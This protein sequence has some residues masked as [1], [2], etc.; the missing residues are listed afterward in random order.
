MSE[1]PDAGHQAVASNRYSLLVGLVVAVI[2]VI[3]LV[4]LITKS[5]TKTLGFGNEVKGSKLA[6]FAV[7]DVTSSLEGDANIDPEAACEVDLP[8]A[9]RLCDFAQ[10]PL[11][12][13]FWFT[14]GGDCEA[15]QDVVDAVSGRYRS[16][17]GFLSINV[18][19]RREDVAAM[20]R[21]RGWSMPVGHDRDGALSNLYRVG[22]CPTF[23]FARSGLRLEEAVVGELDR[24]ELSQKVEGLLAAEGQAGS[25]SGKADSAA[26]GEGR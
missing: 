10:R 12:I 18:R 19:D 7:P 21:G 16:R 4:N 9:I 24:A 15:Q 8:G 13:S 2:A 1:R 3:V 17:V 26:A 25:R 14:R 11:V 5:D 23:V 6:P 20:A 22:G